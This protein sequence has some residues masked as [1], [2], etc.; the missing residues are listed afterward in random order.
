[1][2]GVMWMVL[3]WLGSLGIVIAGALFLGRT[4][5]RGHAPD[6]GDTAALA[7]LEQRFA[8]GEIDREEFQDRRRVVLS[9][10]TEASE[11]EH[12]R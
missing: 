7:I 11:W 5:F 9:A 1:M 6:D 3:F 8:R 2:P 4:W 10:G 12:Q